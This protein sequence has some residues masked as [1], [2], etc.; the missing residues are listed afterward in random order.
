[1]TRRMKRHLGNSRGGVLVIIASALA[2]MIGLTALIVDGGFGLITRNELHNIADAASL[3]GARKL[4]KIYEALS[5][6]AQQTYT[7]TGADRAAIIA[8]MNNVSMQN[9]AGGIAIPIPDDSS[10]VQIGH[11]SGT[12]F[13]ERNAHPDAVHVTARRDD[14]SA[15]N[16]R[17]ATILA[18]LFGVSQMSVSVSATAAL[19]AVKQIA[20]GKLDC[21]VGIPRGYPSSGSGC[22][23]IVFSGQGACAGWH[24]YFESPANNQ[25]LRNL[26]DGD[27]AKR[28]V[29]PNLLQGT[30]PI[31]AAKVGD[32][33]NFNGGQLAS[34]FSN[35]Q[36]LYNAKKN[37]SGE[38]N[39]TI[40]VYDIDACA[41][42]P[43]G[44]VAIAGFVSATI[45]G[46]QSGSIINARVNCDIIDPGPG[47]GGT[48]GDLG[49]IP[50][51]VQ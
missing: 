3:A 4:G 7:L 50:A 18:P 2:A 38:W 37:V 49:S 48:V 41:T 5:P 12:T 30:Y 35:F 39:T 23:N 6:S 28:A 17:L 16:S 51:L 19:T 25:K 46:I 29:P 15:G 24:T 43:A 22:T 34:A 26:L 27:G 9:Q 32:Q 14:T 21:P 31:P 8:Y 36:N 47:S 1:M 40:V 44:P 33:F 45:T 13:T 11:W 10:I 20:A 42:N